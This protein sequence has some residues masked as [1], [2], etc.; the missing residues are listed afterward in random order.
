MPRIEVVFVEDAKAVYRRDPQRHDFMTALP[1]ALKTMIVSPD[2]QTV[3]DWARP[4]SLVV[5]KAEPGAHG[6]VLLKEPRLVKADAADPFAG[7]TSVA[8]FTKQEEVGYALEY[9]GEKEIVKVSVAIRG[10]S[11]GKRVS[12]GGLPVK[13]R[14]DPVISTPGC[15]LARA[16]VSLA[17][18]P[19][20]AGTYT[21][22][23]AVDDGAQR[24]NLDQQFRIE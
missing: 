1:V 19:I 15:G 2:L 14:L 7:I 11:E 18:L 6:L 22:A 4:E 21:F 16:S 23:V 17:D 13:A 5:R 9:C 20:S 10:M 3:P 24:Y 12:I 8:V